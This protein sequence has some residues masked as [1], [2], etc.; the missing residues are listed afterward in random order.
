MALRRFALLP[1]VLWL[2]ALSPVD[3]SARRP[4]MKDLRSQLNR[5]YR[6]VKRSSTRWIIVHTSE[7]G[8]ESTL[9]T[10]TR[11]KR[12]G[13]GGTPGGHAHYAIDREGK[14]YWILDPDLRADHAGLSLWQGVADLS[15][16]SVGIEL[17]AYHTSTITPG[18]YEALGRLIAWLRL[19]YHLPDE[20]VLTHCQVAYGRPNAWHRR[21]HRGRKK[22]AS[23]FDR[24]RIGLKPFPWTRDPD[25]VSG[26]LTEDPFLAK[27][28]YRP[29]GASAVGTP[30]VILSNVIGPENTAW[31]IAGEDY[32]A[33]DT[34]YILPDKRSLTGDQ[35]EKELGWNRLPAGT[36]VL[37]NQSASDAEL[38]AASPEEKTLAPATTPIMVLSADRT[39]WSLAG[40]DYNRAGTYYL[41]PNGRM[42]AGTRLRDWDNLP[43]G[44][45]MLVGYREPVLLG[46]KKGQTPW[47]LAGKA[48]RD[49][50]TVYYLPGRGWVTGD[51]MT[52][53]D[54]LP[55][56]AS[57]LL[58]R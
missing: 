24:T 8:R 1:L 30:E 40:T 49:A 45:R 3:G 11:G 7:A 26:R 43:D 13:R 32:D 53:F 10:L 12:V 15:D 57:I 55:R 35:V 2:F 36:R 33:P 27:L 51:Q 28:L 39:A 22:C 50:R 21:D 19:H 44:T 16:H 54:D 17:V 6:K 34:V 58:P 31:T 46:P 37:L 20:A 25:V 14:I 18:Q 56:G 38:V 5:S 23:N 48:C 9:R 41:L 47:S 52:R 29:G 4:G 42:E